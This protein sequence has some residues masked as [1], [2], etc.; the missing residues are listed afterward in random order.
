MRRSTNLAR[1][2]F[3]IIEVVVVVMILG[4]IASIAAPRLF[5]TSDM[6]VDNGARQT[7]GVI[8]TAIDS[9]AAQHDGKL[10]GA[11]GAATTL[12]TDLAAYLRGPKFP[13]CPVGQA[14]NNDVLVLTGGITG[15][16]TS[17]GS[18]SW[19]YFPDSGDFFI[20]STDVSTD[21]VTPYDEF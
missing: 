12:K 1:C 20:N 10:P 17:A 14:K 16:G 5:R 19:I 8:R 7:L 11:D 15:I 6:A 2:A 21:K 4:I 18:Y 9:F 3:T 13:A